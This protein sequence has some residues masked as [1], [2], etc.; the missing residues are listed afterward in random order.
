M[1]LKVLTICTCIV[2]SVFLCSCSSDNNTGKLTEQDKIELAKKDAAKIAEQSDVIGEEFGITNEVKGIWD[3]IEGVTV[4]NGKL[5][6]NALNYTVTKIN[7]FSDNVEAGIKDKYLNLEDSE[8]LDKNGQL[9]PSVKFIVAEIMVK[10]LRA[11]SELN[12]TDLDLVYCNSKSMLKKADISILSIPAYFSGQKNKSDKDYYEYNLAVGQSK[13]MNIGWYV[14][15]EK[16]DLSNIY[17]AFNLYLD[18]HRS[19]VKLGL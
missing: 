10:N 17:L 3:T 18:E 11:S 19:F 9:K 5:I 8:I 14:D 4:A 13:T 2:I 15:T 16:Y 1:N 12:I 7:I 6:P